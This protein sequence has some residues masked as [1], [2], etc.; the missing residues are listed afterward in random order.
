MRQK[1]ASIVD[2][3]PDH[4]YSNFSPC[5]PPYT[6][7]I[8]ALMLRDVESFVRAARFLYG[9]TFQYRAIEA[10]TRFFEKRFGVEVVYDRSLSPAPNSSF[11]VHVLAERMQKAGIISH[12]HPVNQLCD[13]PR[14]HRWNAKYRT[15]SESYAS[16][17]SFTDEPKALISTLA[18]ALERHLWFE[19]SDYFKN[20]RVATVNQISNMGKFISP[21]TFVGLTPTQR[22]SGHNL[23]ITEHSTYTWIKGN[24]LISQKDIWLPAQTVSPHQ[25]ARKLIQQKLEPSIRQ[26]VTTGLATHEDQNSAILSGLL[27]VIERDAFMIT[28]LNQLTLPLVDC[29]ELS[30]VSTTMR[31]L[32]STCER[33]KLKVHIV[34]LISDAPTHVYCAVIEDETKNEPVLSLGLKAHRDPA[35]CAEHAITEALRVR[36]DARNNTHSGKSPIS[37]QQ[38]HHLNR[39][40]YWQQDNNYRKLSFLYKGETKSLKSKP[41]QNDNPTEHLTRLIKWCKDNHYEATSVTFT[42]S[43][44]NITP[45]HVEMVVVPELQP[46]YFSEDLPHIGGERLKTIPAMF[47]YAAREPFTAEPHPF[48]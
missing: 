7:N 29:A 40:Q 38:V 6:Y 18:E 17:S 8:M 10:F 21:E 25:D 20:S 46:L 4:T 42:N 44:K 11:P 36:Q 2:N 34:E 12:Y 3:S 16:G 41:W 1:V 37:K 27:E 15:G 28:W 45:W 9:D 47:G 33:Y 30:E 23:Q 24:S 19:T 31:A 35:I 39:S 14:L 43:K 13:E 5:A 32:L 26:I 48:V 22:A